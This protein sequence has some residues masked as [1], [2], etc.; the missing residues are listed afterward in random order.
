MKTDWND[1]QVFLAIDRGR[2]ARDAAQRML[3]SHSTILR[4]LSAFEQRIGSRLFDRTPDGFQITE[5]GGII[6]ARAQQIEAEI[7]ELER[8][9]DG[10]DT[11]L[12]GQIRLT[13]PPPIA[14]FLL[15]PILVS[16][17][18]QYPLIDIELVS[19]Y[20]YTDLSRRDADIAIRF[21]K[22]T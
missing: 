22:L 10:G 11:Q 14:Q 4:R 8:S 21:F 7:L 17:K 13:V 6:R 20:G 15:L 3:C 2:T 19:T 9:I 12:K 5:A 1:L 16:F 18:D